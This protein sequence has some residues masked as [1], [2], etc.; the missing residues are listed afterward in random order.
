ML[1]RKENFD[2]YVSDIQSIDDKNGSFF[3][4]V[5]LLMVIRSQ[6]QEMTSSVFACAL[7]LSCQTLTIVHAYWAKVDYESQIG[8]SDHHDKSQREWNEHTSQYRDIPDWVNGKYIKDCLP[9]S[10]HTL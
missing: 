2:V 8:S 6:W 3:F 1:N 10:K 7:L 5:I 4:L 9:T